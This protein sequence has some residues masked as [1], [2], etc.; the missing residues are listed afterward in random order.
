MRRHKETSRHFVDCS[1]VQCD[2]S[3][4]L[5]RGTCSAYAAAVRLWPIAYT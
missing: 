3:Q 1:S 5:V 4:T 2:V